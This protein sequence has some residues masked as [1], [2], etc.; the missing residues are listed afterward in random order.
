MTWVLLQQQPAQLL[1]A[2]AEIHHDGDKV[3]AR[4][5]QDIV[6]PSARAQLTSNLRIPPPL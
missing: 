1:E 2:I 4:Y 5:W 3:P 6:L